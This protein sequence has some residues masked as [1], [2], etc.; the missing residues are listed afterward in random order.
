MPAR[1][2]AIDAIAKSGGSRAQ[3]L[4]IISKML[5]LPVAVAALRNGLVGLFF[6]PKV[7]GES[8]R[9]G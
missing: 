4:N 8:Q 9:V 2:C 7:L 6:V 3:E 1:R 5:S